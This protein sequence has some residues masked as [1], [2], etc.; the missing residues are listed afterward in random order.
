MNYSGL[1]VLI[2]N[3]L[4]FYGDACGELQT[5]ALKTFDMYFVLLH[6]SKGQKIRENWS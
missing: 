6:L 3:T 4:G 5:A 1:Y 2:V